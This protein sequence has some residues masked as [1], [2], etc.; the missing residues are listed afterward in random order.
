MIEMTGVSH[1]ADR[2]FR[3]LSDGEKQ[4]ILFARAL[5]QEPEILIM[6]E[7]MSYLDIKHKLEMLEIL[8]NLRSSKSLTVIMAL[9]EASFAGKISDKILMLKDKKVFGYGKTEEVFTE[10]NIKR[11]Y[12]LSDEGWA[13][14]NSGIVLE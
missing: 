13:F 4:R 11:L 9:H 2:P 6:D 8:K 10:D 7:P 14:I 1:L 3:K 5:S 12:D